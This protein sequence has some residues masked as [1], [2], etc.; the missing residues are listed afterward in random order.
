MY[1]MDVCM[2]LFAWKNY[3]FSEPDK[4]FVLKVKWLYMLLKS[5][6]NDNGCEFGQNLEWKCCSLLLHLVRS[7]SFSICS[8]LAKSRIS[9][10]LNNIC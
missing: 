3:I 7:F 8:E 6:W 4:A 9:R 2:S 10:S 1:N 5:E